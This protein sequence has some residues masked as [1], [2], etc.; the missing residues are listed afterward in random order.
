MK[1][2]SLLFLL[3]TCCSLCAWSAQNVLPQPNEEEGFVYFTADEATADPAA[4]KINL[5][6]NVTLV[7]QTQTGEVR[8][9]KGE[10]ITF[11]QI[12]TTLF[13]VF[14]NIKI[15]SLCF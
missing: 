8:T 6:G 2:K 5:K 13:Y 14:Y 10:D 1:T 4:K 12:N 15:Y 7:Q 3:F 11:D 9:A